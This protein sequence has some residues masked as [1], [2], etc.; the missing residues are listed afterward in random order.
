MAQSYAKGIQQEMDAL[1]KQNAEIDAAI[2]AL[3]REQ[4]SSSQLQ[5]KPRRTR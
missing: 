4:S 5:E 1:L 3:E 2:A